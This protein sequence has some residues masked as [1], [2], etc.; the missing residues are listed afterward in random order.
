M[1][2]GVLRAC[3]MVLLLAA[4][5]GPRPDPPPASVVVPPEG[6]RTH[7]PTRAAM[8]TQWWT[9]F[10]DPTLDALV[11]TALDSN[12]DLA[13]AAERVEEARAQ[14]RF[15]SGLAGPDIALALAGGRQRTVGA[16]GTGLTQTYGQGQVSMAYEVDL[17]GRLAATTGSARATLLASE[18]AR[19]ALQLSL[20]ATTIN[21]YVTLRALD[22]RLT[23]L[24]DTLK[25]RGETMR[26]ARRRA[27]TGYGSQLEL[28]QAETDYYGAAQLIPATRLAIARQEDGL[29]VLLGLVPGDVDRGN[30]LIALRLPRVP[31]TGVPSSLLRA[32]PDIAQAEH[33]VVAADE[34]LDAARAAFLPRLLLTAQGGHVDSDILRSG[35]DLFAVG[36][37]I[38]APLFQRGKLRAQADAAASRRDQ[39]AL[40][41]RRT[42]LVAFREVEDAL[43]A[44][45]RTEEQEA[46]TASQRDAA[47]AALALAINRYRAGY[48]PYLEQQDLQRILLTAEIA[49]INARAD[50]LSATVSLYQALGGGWSAPQ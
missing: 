47:S 28:H 35:I 26:V 37:S 42:V 25:T 48:S 50:R 38:L 45:R 5:A 43:A 22:A 21:G 49:L 1:K 9:A 2:R 24:Q 8:D 36:G 13:I 30:D 31:D 6:W 46:E 23:L 7:P 15:A 19:D 10:G 11:A 40:A 33:Q 27:E 34:S 17:F 4:C 41:Y 29:R 3:G 32:R 18:D 20:I 44:I 39:A 14:Y 12:V 16:F